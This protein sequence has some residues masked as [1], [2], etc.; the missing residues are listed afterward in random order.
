MIADDTVLRACRRKHVASGEWIYKTRHETRAAAVA[1][2][3]DPKQK[4]YACPDC[5]F[6]HLGHA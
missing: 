4:P 2:N 6:W 3:T 5:S 1:A